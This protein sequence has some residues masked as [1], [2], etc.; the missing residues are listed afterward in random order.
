MPDQARKVVLITG[1]SSGFG[2]LAALEFARAGWLVCASVRRPESLTALSGDPEFQSLAGAVSLRLMDVTDTDSVSGAVREFYRDRGRIDALVNNAGYGLM[3]AVEDLSIDELRRQF[4]TNFF[5]AVRLIQ[6]VMPVF[7]EQKRGHI[8]TVSSIAGLVGMPLSAGYCASKFALEGLCESLRFEAELYGIR[9]SNVH[10]GF[11]STNFTTSSAKFGTGFNSESS[12]YPELNR[13][14]L[15]RRNETGF[16]DPR[17]VAELLLELAEG[18]RA[19]YWNTIG[20]KVAE[21]FLFK[22]LFGVDL[23]QKIMR[24]LMKVPGPAGGGKV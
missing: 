14:F 18:R 11:F 10:P 8:I 20:S 19:G 15:R 1:C 13:Y 17:A 23:C 22:R 9:V 12:P 4:E 16:S 6:A 7:R 3:G 5:G 21:V 24:K 2:R